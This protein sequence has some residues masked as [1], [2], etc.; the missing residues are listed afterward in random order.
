MSLIAKHAR[1]SPESLCTQYTSSNRGLAA[2]P[3]ASVIASDATV[4]GLDAIKV[5]AHA[6][7]STGGFGGGGGGGAWHAPTAAATATAT[8]T[9]AP[10]ARAVTPRAAHSGG[11]LRVE[12]RGDHRAG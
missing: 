4:P 2:M 12:H 3:D 11:S 8:A 1:V 10:G 5:F 7:S 9:S 6:A